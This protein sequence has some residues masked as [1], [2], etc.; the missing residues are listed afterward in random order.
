[1]EGLRILT[2]E[3]ALELEPALADSVY[4]ALYAPT[5]G[6]VCPFLMN[7]AYAENAAINGVKF[8]LERVCRIYRDAIK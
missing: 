6:I 5:G 2:R 8:N 4:A 3:E 1:M 7:I